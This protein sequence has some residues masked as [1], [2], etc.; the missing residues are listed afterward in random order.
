[1]GAEIDGIYAPVSYLNGNNNDVTGALI[2]ASVRAGYVEK[3]NRYK[4]Y[5]NLRYLA[6]GAKGQSDNYEPPSDGYVKNWLHFLT[7]STLFSWNIF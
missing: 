4:I 2:D 6:G 5:L 3:N 7:V 1:M